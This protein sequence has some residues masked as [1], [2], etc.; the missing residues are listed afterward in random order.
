MVYSQNTNIR[1]HLAPNTSPQQLFFKLGTP[2]SF[3]TISWF[4][5][6]L[7]FS[8]THFSSYYNEATFS[9]TYFR[10]T[11]MFFLANSDNHQL[12]TN[13]LINYLPYIKPKK[14]LKILLKNKNFLK[15]SSKILKIS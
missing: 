5:H 6:S 4:N 1:S 10:Q 11:H 8:T 12:S 13:N 14:H 3:T 9:S 15:K 2:S 7:T